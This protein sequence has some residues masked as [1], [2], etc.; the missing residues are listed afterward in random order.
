MN[1]L[2]IKGTQEFMGKEIPVV[3]GGFGE[4]QKVILA[5]PIAE[6]HETRL[7]KVNELINKHLDEFEMGIDLLDLMSN[8]D[9]LNLAKGL[10]FI[11]NNRQK[12]Y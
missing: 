5:K 3:E 7:D 6:V 1:E 11:T 4:G 10:G 8:E 2:Q 9:S 12:N